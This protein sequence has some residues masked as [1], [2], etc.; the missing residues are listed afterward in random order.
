MHKNKLRG[1]VLA[2]MLCPLA[3][4]ADTENW[5]AYWSLG[6]VNHDHPP[7]LERI[8]SDADSVPGIDRTELALDMFGFYFPVD[9]LENSAAGFVINGSTDSLTD[10]FG[11]SV[12]FNTYL[13]GLSFM[14]FLGSE[15]GDG[16]FVRGDFG[17]AKAVVS[18]TGRF[19]SSTSS[20]SGTGYLLGVGFGIPLSSQARIILGANTSSKKIDS[21]TYGATQFTV[22]ILW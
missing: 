8:M 11:N 17:I 3:A 21:K 9:V 10:T 22:G 4:M 19:N 1:L 15:I 13:Y 12:N 5:Y 6:T 7:E 2:I 14:S 16:L 18:S 20:E